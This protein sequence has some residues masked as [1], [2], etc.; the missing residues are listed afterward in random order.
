MPHATR[1]SRLTGLLASVLLLTATAVV[2]SLALVVIVMVRY[3]DNSFERVEQIH[4]YA[5]A[6]LLL[7][8]VVMAAIGGGRFLLESLTNAP[9]LV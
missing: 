7:G 2:S 3:A 9:P 6:A 5:V 4:G 8:L 1:V